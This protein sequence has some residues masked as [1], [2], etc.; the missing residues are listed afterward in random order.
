LLKKFAYAA[1]AVAFLWIPSPTQV[2]ENPP[3]QTA[4]FDELLGEDD[5]A[6][7]AILFGANL[8]GNLQTCDCA[9]PRGGLARRIGYVEGFKKKFTQTA[10]LQLEAGQFLYDSLG[11]PDYVMLQNE[12][13]ARAFSRWPVEVINLGRYDLI[14]ARRML[15]REGLPE[16]MAA[17][18]M[19]KNLISANGIF[20]P[21]VAAPPAFIIKEVSGPRI[22][23]RRR[24]LR[25]GFVG[26]AEPIKP[27]GGV[28]DGTVKNMFEVGRKTVLAARKKC[29]VLVIV[30]H[31][32]FESALRLATENP[33]ADVVIAGNA[34]TVYNLRKV[35]RTT[36]VC[37][38]P[39]NTEQGDL[40]LYIAPDGGFTF[41]F[42]STSLDATVPSDP[43][44]AA[45]TEAA[46]KEYS[47]FRER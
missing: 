36:V 43:A 8:R 17:L 16:R 18:P 27:S 9:H 7:L 19:L 39:G 31:C 42:R 44:A 25:I 47:R 4:S 21:D 15:V 28:F 22:K 24:V 32:E 3:V 12:Q 11:Y 13:V 20:E 10:V 45:Y 29:D 34:A 37:A 5:G 38:A 46:R 23:G 30:A 1:A 6:A 2:P 14:W 26:L 33:E 35:G 40:R 41:K